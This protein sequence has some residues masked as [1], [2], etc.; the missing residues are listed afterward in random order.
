[1]EVD[2]PP[3]DEAARAEAQERQRRL[4][5]PPGSL[6]RLETLAAE[7]AGLTGDPTPALEEAAIATVAADHGVAAEGVSAFPQAVTAQMVANFAADGA[8]VN[9]LA[10]TVDARN[11]IV[12][13]GV[14]GEYP[15]GAGVI[16]KAVAEGTDNIAAGTA[17]SR[18]QAREAVQAGRE[19]VAEHAPEADVIGLGDMGIANTTASAAV[20]AAVTGAAP[21]AVTGHGTGVDEATYE[22]KIEVVEQ[23]LDAAPPDPEDGLDVL[24]S[25]GGFEIGGLAGIA[26]EAASRRTPVVLDGFITG[27]GALVA[28]A[29]DER[30]TDY[31]LPSHDSVEGGHAVQ[32]D[33]LGLEPLFNF[34]MRL[35][36]GTGAALAIGVYRGACR[37]HREM[38]TF[39]EAGI[40][41]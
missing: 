34:D 5:K 33:H 36:E 39:E 13:L 35:G 31:L 8:A 10:G 25:V 17:M 29:I 1:M 28:A 40:D 22:H 27:A 6:G 26:L 15:D 14:A 30:V 23:A 11:L 12:D 19:I 16:E 7:I 2:I 9:A 32:Y 41:A 4:T 20:T 18:A 24:R 38:A 3:V 21:E 37:A